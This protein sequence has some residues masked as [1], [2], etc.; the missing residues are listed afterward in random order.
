MLFR[1]LT[2]LAR[3]LPRAHLHNRFLRSGMRAH[4]HE[5]VPIAPAGAKPTEPEVGP[6]E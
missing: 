4:K 1:S 2:E 3:F 6:T 5:L